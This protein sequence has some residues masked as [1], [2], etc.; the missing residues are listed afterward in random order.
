MIAGTGFRLVPIDEAWPRHAARAVRSR[1]PMEVLEWAIRQCHRNEATC[2]E[3]DDG[4][5]ILAAGPTPYGTRAKVLLAAGR[6]GA[7][8]SREEDLVNVA[9]DIGAIEVSFRTDRPRAWRRVLGAKWESDG[10]RFWRA[11]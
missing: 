8:A 3:C 1:A 6:P 11:V 2:L 10:E 4:M 7:L 9:R 5:V